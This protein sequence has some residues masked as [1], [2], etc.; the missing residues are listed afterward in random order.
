MTIIDDVKKLLNGTL[1]EKLEIV[2]RR[3]KER[4]SSLV[5][6]DNVPDQLDYISYEVTLKRFNRIGQEGMTSYTQEG[7]SMV[8]PDSDFSEYQQEIDDFIKKNDPNYS[9]RTSVARFF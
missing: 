2:E 5:K 4:L 7:L 6:L 1:D 9:N 3:T 8:F